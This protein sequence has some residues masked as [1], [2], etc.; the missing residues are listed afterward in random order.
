MRVCLVSRELAPFWGGGIGAYVAR[1][2]TAWR[3][4]GHEIHLVTVGHP[5][6]LADAPRLFPGIGIHIVEPGPPGENGSRYGFQRHAAAVRDLLLRLHAES[7]LDYAEFPDYWAEGYLA[8]IAARTRRAFDGVVL[9]VRL[10]TP[11]TEARAFNAEGPGDEEVARLCEAED[12]AIREADLV[13]SPTAALLHIVRQRLGRCGWASG[14]APYPF[15]AAAEMGA[16]GPGGPPSTSPDDAPTVLYFGRLERRKGVEL[17]LSAAGAV[18]D[19]SP[20]AR[21]R[22][23]GGDT[24]T[25]A[26]SGSMRAH[27]ESMIKPQHRERIAFEEPQPRSALYDAVRRATAAGGCCCFPSLWENFPNT[28]VEAMALGAPVVASDAGG[29]AEIVEDGVSGVLFPSGNAGALAAALT[30]VL[31][32]GQLRARIAAA[33]PGRI[34]SLCDPAAVVARTIAAVETAR[35]PRRYVKGAAR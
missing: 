11:T 35:A 30:R 13:L 18:L 19:A 34:A 31:G 33:A 15:D 12:F 5:G 32:D 10:H 17:L 1:M 23:I 25:G 9:G 28:C 6:L 4:A 22:L 7:P 2:A 20:G 27:L 29:M 16:T 3:D 21:I 26:G 14:V 8:I 24:N